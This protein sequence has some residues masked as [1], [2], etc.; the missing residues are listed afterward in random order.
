MGNFDH[1]KIPVVHNNNKSH[2]FSVSSKGETEL[3]HF[4]WI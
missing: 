3:L 1:V 2:F 4:T